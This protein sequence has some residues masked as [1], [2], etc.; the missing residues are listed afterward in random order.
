LVKAT[1]EGATP[2]LLSQ[3][4]VSRVRLETCH[5]YEDD[6]N[7]QQISKLRAWEL[8]SADEVL[9]LD[10]DLVVSRS[11]TQTSGLLGTSWPMRPSDQEPIPVG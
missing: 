4:V 3:L 8:S 9:Y 11:G 7:G 2:L 5:A 1:V 6:Y 10:A